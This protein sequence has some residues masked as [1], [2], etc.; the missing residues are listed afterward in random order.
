MDFLYFFYPLL[1]CL[2]PLHTLFAQ[3]IGEISLKSYLQAL[4]I[5]GF[6]VVAGCLGLNIFVK[7]LY[8]AEALFCVNFFMIL[9][10]NY[11]FIG[12]FSTYKR[13]LKSVKISFSIC[14]ILLCALI[15][16]VLYIIN[17]VSIFNAAAKI[18]FYAALLITFFVVADIAAKLSNLRTKCIEIDDSLSGGDFPDI[19]HILADAH[20]GFFDSEYCDEEFKKGLEQRGFQIYKLAKSNYNFTHLSVSSMLNMDYVY[21][22]VPDSKD[23]VFP[24]KCWP[25]YAKNKVFDALKKRGYRFNFV[26][27]KWFINMHQHNYIGKNDTINTYKC[28]T[29]TIIVMMF[30]SSIFRLFITRTRDLNYKQDIEELLAGYKKLS[31]IKTEQPLYNY[32][33]ILAPHPPYFKDEQGNDLPQDE[34]SNNKHYKSYQKYINK[35]YLELIDSIKRNMKKN[36]V[37]LIHSDHSIWRE[38]KIN[39]SYHILLCAYF[40][41]KYNSSCIPQNCTLVNLFRYLFNEVFGENHS[42]LNDEFYKTMLYEYKIVKLDNI[43]D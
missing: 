16:A 43:G 37:I 20:C 6:L 35:K 10:A 42:I 4:C 11:V 40:P 9:Y 3:N 41:E 30:F 14:Y 36:S 13:S 21:N 17:P 32:M 19:Y 7:N 39:S 23:C 1:L 12:M 25:Y 38:D 22:V 5:V 29:N 18:I 8:T 2:I 24:V 34:Y 28:S 15:S 33:H 31:K 27:H 26:F